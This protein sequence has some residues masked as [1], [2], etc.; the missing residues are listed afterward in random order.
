MTSSPLNTQHPTPNTQSGALFGLDARI[1][2]AVFSIISVVAG[3]AMVLNMD[4][5]S[6][7]SLAS[8]LADTSR[9][10]ETAHHDLNTD[11]FQAL[12]EPS[13]KHAFQALYDSTMLRDELRGRW[14]G[15]YVTFTTTRN[16]KY[17]EMYL[18]KAGDNHTDGCQN[19]PVCYLW[20]VY[21]DV[22]PA[23][24]EAVNEV[25]DGAH[26]DAPATN[27]RLQWSAG[28]AGN[29]VLYYRIGPALTPFT[30]E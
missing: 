11:I 26:E 4:T 20:L 8:E 19:A 21:D 9:A 28:T 18:E 29:K 12:D 5:T 23:V 6:A 10:I 30:G 2:L 3:V 1:A 15:P 13:P 7:K 16:P 22:R 17:G 25:M 24:A 27:G 14:N